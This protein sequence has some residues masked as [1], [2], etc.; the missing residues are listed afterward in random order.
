[1]KEELAA[2]LDFLRRNAH[3]IT[4]QRKEIARRVF[5][6]HEHFSAEELQ[7]LL[8]AKN[9]SRATVYRTLTLMVDAGLVKE[10]RFGKGGRLYEHVIGHPRH[11][12]LICDNCGA[13][14]EIDAPEAEKALKEAVDRMGYE[15]LGMDVVIHGICGKCRK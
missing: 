1:M 12:H 5:A 11:F 3:R 15:I 8:R 14:E 4:G 6:L 7:F 2:F 13:I 9:I 10:H